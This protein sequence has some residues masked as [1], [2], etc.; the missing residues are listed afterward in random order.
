MKTSSM[1]LT[2]GDKL[3]FK[4]LKAKLHSNQYSKTECFNMIKEYIQ[5]RPEDEPQRILVCGI[6]WLKTGIAVNS[7]RL[8]KVL[9]TTNSN[10]AL[11]LK[12]IGFI[13]SSLPCT[14]LL[15]KIPALKTDNKMVREWTMKVYSPV[16]PSPNIE[17]LPHPEEGTP[18]C[19]SPSVEEEC[20]DFEILPK[21]TDNIYSKNLE[22]SNS[23]DMLSFFDDPFCCLPIF[24]VDNMQAN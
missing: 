8:C 14:E 2:D 5:S 21:K 11:S 23:I 19:Q 3:L 15:D 9:K 20:G 16:T 7:K 1:L 22:S 24:L 6:C 13:P 12:K 18:V 4:E 17:P 10:L